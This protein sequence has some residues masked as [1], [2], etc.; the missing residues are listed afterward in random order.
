MISTFD[1]ENN[2]SLQSQSTVVFDLAMVL[3]M[4]FSHMLNMYRTL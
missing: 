3:K 4:Y 1:K 2:H